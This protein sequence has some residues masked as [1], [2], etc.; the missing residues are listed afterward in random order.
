MSEKIQ[1]RSGGKE[2]FFAKKAELRAQLDELTGKM[3]EL[4]ARDL[5]RSRGMFFFFFLKRLGFWEKGGGRRGVVL[6]IFF[7]RAKNPVDVFFLRVSSMSLFG[8]FKVSIVSLVFW[9]ELA[10]VDVF[11]FFYSLF[12]VLGCS[13]RNR[14]LYSG[15]PQVPF[16]EPPKALIV[17]M[18]TT[19]EFTN[20]F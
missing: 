2:E 10:P 20:N 16:L 19:P 8:T 14:L 6:L 15:F 12:L 7:R 4:Q 3:D 11:F 9:G 5:F 17:S 18:D 13:P 1:A